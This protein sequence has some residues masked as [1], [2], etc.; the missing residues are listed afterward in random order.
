VGY[1]F[2]LAVLSLFLPPLA[3]AIKD[4]VGLSLLVNIL[5]TVFGL[6]FLGVLHALFVIL[7]DE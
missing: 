7:G 5:L 6:W 1:K 3:V 4:G 2:G